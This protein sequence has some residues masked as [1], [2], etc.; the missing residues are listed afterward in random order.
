LLLTMILAVLTAVLLIV[1]VLRLSRQPGGKVNLGD[2]EFALGKDTVFAPKVASLG[3]LVFAP[4]R[5]SITLYVQHQGN[6]AAHGWLAFG[7]QP[8]GEA[9]QC[10]VQW[11]STSHDFVDPCTHTVY[12]ADGT[13][14]D[15][16][17]TRVDPKGQVIINLRQ[18]TGTTPATEPPTTLPPASGTGPAPTSTPPTTA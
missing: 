11:R 5:G 3:P 1:F 6:D 9:A 4:L 16:Y 14:L 18:S 17:A 10:V 8:P 7:A 13:G 15:Q 2:Q 12:P